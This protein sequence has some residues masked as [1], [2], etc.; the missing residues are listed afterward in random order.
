MVKYYWPEK[1]TLVYLSGEATPAFWDNLWKRR[2][3]VSEVTNSTGDRLVVPETRRYL[4]HGSKILE[5]GCGIGK[6]V[7]SLNKAGYECCGIDS[8]RETIKSVKKYLPDLPV[9]YGNVTKLAYENNSFDGYWSIGVIEHFYEGYN[10]VLKEMHRVIRPGGYLFVSFPYLS[11]LRQLNIIFGKYAA[12]D[13][14]KKPNDFYQYALSQNTVIKNFE[15]RGFRFI[16][17]RPFDG[18]KGL[19]EEMGLLPSSLP[20]LI[21]LLISGLAIPWSSHCVLLI[22]QKAK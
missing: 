3:I 12:R 21:K 1:N 16:R 13:F 19:R 10:T 2:D 6:Y 5:G 4:N 18:Y 8:A 11:P 22:F 17:S 15:S 14:K 20:K 7:Y 9:K